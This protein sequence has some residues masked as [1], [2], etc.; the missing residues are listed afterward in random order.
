MIL[1]IRRHKVAAHALT[2]WYFDWLAKI[3]LPLN[4]MTICNFAIQPFRKCSFANTRLLAWGCSRDL[5]YSRAIG[6]NLF[7]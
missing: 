2:I 1:S 3:T 4:Q 5:F 7:N 6:I